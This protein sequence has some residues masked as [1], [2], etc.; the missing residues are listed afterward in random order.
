[1]LKI[2]F[3]NVSKCPI[4]KIFLEKITL[5]TIKR[6]GV[7]SVDGKD[8]FLSFASVSEE[9]MKRLNK[10]FRKKNEP[11]DVLSFFEYGSRNEIKKNVDKNMFLGEIILCYN[12]IAKYCKK[13]KLVLKQELSKVV[14]HGVLHLLGFR[15]GAEMFKL[16]NNISI[17]KLKA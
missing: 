15:H 16:Q 4:K 1:M 7:L 8:I 6:S 12:D 17:R 3:N 2:D 13:N 9:E 11:T 5:K 10:K 14:A